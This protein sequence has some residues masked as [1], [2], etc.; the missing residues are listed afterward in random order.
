MLNEVTEALQ[1]W[2]GGESMAAGNSGGAKNGG[3]SVE[4]F[5]RPPVYHFARV[6]ASISA[7]GLERF[8]DRCAAL[9]QG[10]SARG[11]SFS[12]PGA[13]AVTISVLTANA[14]FLARGFSRRRGRQTIEI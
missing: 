9:P 12:R 14:A 10:K 13:W 7:D 11:F 6:S 1:H 3:G 4:L 5:G 8:I 2:S